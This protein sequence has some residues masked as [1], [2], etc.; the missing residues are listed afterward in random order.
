MNAAFR[1]RRRV[2]AVL[3]GE[4]RQGSVAFLSLRR[5]DCG[6]TE[7]FVCRRVSWNESEFDCGGCR[8]VVKVERIGKSETEDEDRERKILAEELKVYVYDCRG[9]MRD[10][11]FS[12]L[13]RLKWIERSR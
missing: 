12:V 13:V 3:K 11:K 2:Y 9:C 8:N 1:E 5:H 6:R 10:S 4:R 7:R